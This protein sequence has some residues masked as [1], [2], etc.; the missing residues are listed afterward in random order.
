VICPAGR[1]LWE[2][3]LWGEPDRQQRRMTGRRRRGNNP[4]HLGIEGHARDFM[5]SMH[6]LQWLIGMGEKVF[7]ILA[8]QEARVQ[9]GALMNSRRL[10]WYASTWD[11]EKSL[12]TW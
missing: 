3:G 1:G 7:G 2:V 9:V 12:E 11:L 6:D 8:F 4:C 10:V 5:K